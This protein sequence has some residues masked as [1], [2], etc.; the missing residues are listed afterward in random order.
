MSEEIYRDILDKIR[1]CS[2]GPEIVDYA[3]RIITHATLAGYVAMLGIFLLEKRYQFLYENILVTGIS[4]LVVSLIRK[5]IGAKRPYET[6][7]IQPLVEK[8]TGGDSF[9]SRH[10]FSIFIVAMAM[11]RQNIWLGFLFLAM[12]LILA[13]LR[14]IAGLHYPRDVIAGALIGVISGGLGFF[15]IFPR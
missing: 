12:G 8:E 6:M 4:L 7:E 5:R 1:A 2:D 13:V 15:V 11:L 3:M 14:V 9:P 10:V